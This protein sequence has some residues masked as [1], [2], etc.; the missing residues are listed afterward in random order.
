MTQCS[1]SGMYW[2]LEDTF[3]PYIQLENYGNMY[4]RNNCIH[5]P[6]HTVS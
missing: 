3:I 4:L 1:L 5:L 6:D 2:R